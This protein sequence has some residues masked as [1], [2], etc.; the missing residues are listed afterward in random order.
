MLRLCTRSC[1]AIQP[2]SQILVS[3][4]QQLVV[5][6]G[7]DEKASG[8]PVV[9][10]RVTVQDAQAPRDSITPTYRL[11]CLLDW[12]CE[13]THPPSQGGCGALNLVGGGSRTLTPLWVQGSLRALPRRRAEERR[14]PMSFRLCRQ[15]GPCQQCRWVLHCAGADDRSR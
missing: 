3:K 14:S 11:R 9:R 6:D 13:C 10:T 2:L 7:F 1:N 12:G 4:A 8:G 15:R 5:A